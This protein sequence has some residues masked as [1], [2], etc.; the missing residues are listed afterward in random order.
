VLIAEQVRDLAAN[1][2]S[3]EEVR[4]LE[5]AGVLGLLPDRVHEVDGQI[6]AA[7]RPDAQ[8]I[9]VAV[10]A[11]GMTVEMVA[12]DGAELAMHS[13]YM[14]VWVLPLLASGAL[15]VP[16][17]VLANLITARIAA[18]KRRSEEPPEVVFRETIIEDG[19]VQERE[20]RGPAREIEQMLRK[21]VESGE[22]AAE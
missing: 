5:R 16:C 18:A 9:R 7:F 19:K 21:R 4:D 1:S 2:I 3:A 12:P 14:A 11:A 10:E 15:S 6:V 8:A 13:Q 22:G 20:L 17:A